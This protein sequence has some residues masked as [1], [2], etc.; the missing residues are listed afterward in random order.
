MSMCDICMRDV[1]DGVACGQCSPDPDAGLAKL[2]RLL[3]AGWTV[4]WN[5]ETGC[6]EIEWWGHE[7]A[8]SG[9][10]LAEALAQ[11]LDGGPDE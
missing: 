7:D 2:E 11:V 8:V 9:A 1:E 5:S 3:R 6:I 10:T 4:Y